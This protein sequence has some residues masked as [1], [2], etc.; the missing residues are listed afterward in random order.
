VR[1]AGARIVGAALV[2]AI[3]GVAGS[4]VFGE[5]GVRHL[6]RLRAER[7]DLARQAFALLERNARM[8]DEIARL[9]SDDLY[10]EGLARRQLG[11]VKPGELVYRARRPNG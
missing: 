2:L 3:V 8:H 6:R 10:L 7:R 9:R 5:H 4:A 1:L 11:L